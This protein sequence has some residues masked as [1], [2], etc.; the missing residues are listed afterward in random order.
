[1][2]L[3]DTTKKWELKKNATHHEQA[4]MFF[5]FPV[6]AIFCLYSQAKDVIPSFSFSPKNHETA[7]NMFSLCA[8]SYSWGSCHVMITNSDRPMT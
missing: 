1:M 2:K 7:V 6:V 8:Q 3:V 5:L 4:A